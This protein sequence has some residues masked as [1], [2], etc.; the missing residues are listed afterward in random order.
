MRKA[1]R[2]WSHGLY[3]GL[4]A[5]IFWSALFDDS[6]TRSHVNHMFL[7]LTEKVLGIKNWSIILDYQC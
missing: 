4:I 3:C 1:L 5:L 6:M 2:S 7:P